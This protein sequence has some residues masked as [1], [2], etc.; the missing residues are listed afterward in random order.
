MQPDPDRADHLD[1]PRARGEADAQRR[2]QQPGKYPF[3]IFHL[4]SILTASSLDKRKRVI[5]NK[6]YLHPRNTI[7]DRGAAFKSI[8]LAGTVIP[9]DQTGKGQAA[10]ARPGYGRGLLDGTDKIPSSVIS[11]RMPVER[12]LE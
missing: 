3:Q 11:M 7:E 5:Y 4:L 9:G 8:V 1:R 6:E 2:C 12:Y 10:E